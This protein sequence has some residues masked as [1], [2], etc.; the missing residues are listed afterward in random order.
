MDQFRS[1]EASLNGADGI[2][3]GVFVAGCIISVLDHRL[4]IPCYKYLFFPAVVTESVLLGYYTP[5]AGSKSIG[6][7]HRRNW[8]IFHWVSLSGD[9]CPGYHNWRKR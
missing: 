8:V 1:K 2:A 6:H 4:K 7:S 5:A 9:R 3:V